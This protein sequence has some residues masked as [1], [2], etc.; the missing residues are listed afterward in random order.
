MVLALG[1][2]A[3][4]DCVNLKTIIIPNR[5]STI[6]SKTFY[7]CSNLTSITI[8]V[9]VTKIDHNAVQASNNLKDLYYAGTKA[10]WDTINIG[11]NA[12]I[13]RATKHYGIAPAKVSDIQELID[14]VNTLR[15]TIGQLNTKSLVKTVK[16]SLPSSGWVGEGSSYSQ[17][18]T[19]ADVT[20]YSK[21]DLQPTPEQLAVFYEKDVTFVV[22]N[23]NGVI[24]V[25]CIGQK[26]TNDYEIQSTITEV[27]HL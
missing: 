9:S 19:I 20:P 22:E 18:V 17:V 1:G 4:S 21:I 5:V 24:T 6:N 15:E 25:Y 16:I 11:D 8:P 27:T 7:A 14:E 12:I 26:P 13:D 23:N 2:Y 10:Q 3:F